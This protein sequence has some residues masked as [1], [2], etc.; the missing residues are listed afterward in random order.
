MT[1]THR[2]VGGAQLSSSSLMLREEI[3]GGA[4]NNPSVRF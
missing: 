1:F 3:R 4:G 2:V